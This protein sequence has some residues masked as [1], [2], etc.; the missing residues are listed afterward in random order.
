MLYWL[1]MFLGASSSGY[2]AW[3]IILIAIWSVAGVFTSLLI[4]IL[5]TLTVRRRRARAGSRDQGRS[6]A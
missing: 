5:W 6:P 3:A 4:G 2:E 1:P